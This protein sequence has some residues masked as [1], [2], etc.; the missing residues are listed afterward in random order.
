MVKDALSAGAVPV[1]V[2]RDAL[3]NVVVIDVGVKHGFHAG[4]EA[5]F[6]IINLAAGLDEL[7]H[8]HA[9]DVDGGCLFLAH[10]CDRW[11]AVYGRSIIVRETISRCVLRIKRD[12][13]K[14]LYRL[15]QVERALSE[16]RSFCGETGKTEVP[17]FALRLA[18]ALTESEE[19]ELS[20][21]A[22]I[23]TNRDVSR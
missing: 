22:V 14:F 8:A 13:R 17:R 9:K 15:G 21:M 11:Y 19:R 7:G 20:M 23:S 4:F 1:A 3:V 6:M 10:G 5:K 12:G 2:A 16:F 18:G